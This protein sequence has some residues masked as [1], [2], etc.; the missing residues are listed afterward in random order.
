MIT[1][2]EDFRINESNN[3]RQILPD[4]VALSNNSRLTQDIATKLADTL[5]PDVFQEFQRWLIH[6]KQFQK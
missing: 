3:I 4:M 5:P 1:N 6:A 2:I